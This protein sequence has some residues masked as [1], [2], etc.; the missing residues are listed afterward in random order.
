MRAQ[1]GTITN[2]DPPGSAVTIP[3]S[4]NPAGAIAGDYADAS[5]MFHGFVRA[6][7]GAITT[8]D[9]PGAGT[10]PG[11]GTF[12]TDGG[13]I[14]PAG[15]IAGEVTDASNVFHGFV[16]AANG[17]I[18]TFDAPGAGTDPGQ[19]TTA[20]GINP[21]GV[22]EGQYIDAANVP[23][24]F[25]RDTN[26]AITAF[27]APGAGTGPFQ[28]TFP[29][30]INPQRAIAG[31]YTDPSNVNHSFVRA[32]NG[33]ITTFDAPGAG[34]G[35]G[36]GSFPFSE[37]INYAGAIAGAYFDSNNVVHGFLRTP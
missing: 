35:P 21:A 8:F 11:Q 28:G 12:M 27:D 26:G 19:G 7:I 9:A 5:F 37:A 3:E 32:A 36:Q 25:V 30:T 20:V 10:A 33:T 1:D 22:I 15:V 2:F 23:H 16:R 31:S 18:T 34:T 6:P 13:C 17:T 29:L 24:G 4:I 14:N